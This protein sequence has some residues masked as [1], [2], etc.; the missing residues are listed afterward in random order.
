VTADPVG[1]T[2]KFSAYV[3]L[4]SD[5]TD[6]IYYSYEYNQYFTSSNSYRY[7]GPIQITSDTT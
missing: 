7:Y 6:L 1:G 5:V 4:K 3:T 2:Y